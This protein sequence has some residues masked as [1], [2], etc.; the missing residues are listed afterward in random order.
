MVDLQPT[1]GAVYGDGNSD[2]VESLERVREWLTKQYPK[3]IETQAPH[4]FW[5]LKAFDNKGRAID[6]MQFENQPERIFIQARVVLTEGMRN[7]L[8]MLPARQRTEFIY[9]IQLRL[10]SMN[11]MYQG[12]LDPLEEIFIQQFIYI[13]S[14]TRDALLDKVF[15]VWRAMLSVLVLLDRQLAGVTT[16]GDTGEL[17]TIN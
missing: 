17:L 16:G 13:D 1:G 6:V 7:S 9:D 14:L 5:F 15:L 11:T 8:A 3:L 2:T 10:L 4:T 12:V